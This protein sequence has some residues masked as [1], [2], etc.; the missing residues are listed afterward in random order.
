MQFLNQQKNSIKKMER[1]STKWRH[2]C[3]TM[4]KKFIEQN[5]REGVKIYI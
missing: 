5:V 4:P 2:K 3:H 1:L